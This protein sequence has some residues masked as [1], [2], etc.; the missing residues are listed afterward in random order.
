MNF[1]GMYLIARRA[2]MCSSRDVFKYKFLNDKPIH[3][4]SGVE[5]VEFKCILT[6]VKYAVRVV[7]SPW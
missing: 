1:W 2:N 5:M 3:F 6:V 7:T 4:A